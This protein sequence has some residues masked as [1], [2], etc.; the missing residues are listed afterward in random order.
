MS[1][2]EVIQDENGNFRIVGATPEEIREMARR[3]ADAGNSD[4]RANSRY[5]T[6]RQV[7]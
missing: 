7:A 6:H 1:R 5:N 4:N 2:I 3:S